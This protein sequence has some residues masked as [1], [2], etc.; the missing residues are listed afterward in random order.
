MPASR[1]REELRQARRDGD[2]NDGG[3]DDGGVGDGKWG[4]RMRLRR[5]RSS[6]LPNRHNRR[7][8]II[9]DGTRLGKLD[10]RGFQ[11]EKNIDD[12]LINGDLTDVQ[13]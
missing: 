10:Q 8:S 5:A 11:I 6:A 1:P 7:D 9:L 3:F 4:I 13:S 2:I 12:Q